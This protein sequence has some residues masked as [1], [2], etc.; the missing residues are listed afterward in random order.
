MGHSLVMPGPQEDGSGG[1]LR[2]RHAL[3]VERHV[4]PTEGAVPAHAVVLRRCET[5]WQL[6]KMGKDSN[7]LQKVSQKSNSICNMSK[8]VNQKA[9]MSECN[10]LC[11]LCVISKQEEI[12]TQ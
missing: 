10:F 9:P 2:E 3:G 4:H 1:A 6:N 8:A 12:L 5:G 11:L 7:F